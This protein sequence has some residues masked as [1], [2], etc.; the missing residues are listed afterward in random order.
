MKL[1]V[2]DTYHLSF[3]TLAVEFTVLAAVLSIIMACLC[4]AVALWVF[5]HNTI[6]ELYP[7]DSSRDNSLSLVYI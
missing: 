2:W 6:G 4:I 1:V 7:H 3:T 5:V